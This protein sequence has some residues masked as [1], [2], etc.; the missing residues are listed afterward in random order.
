MTVEAEQ[1]VEQAVPFF[2]ITDMAAALR[3][4]VDGLGFTMTKQ[5]TPGGK[6]LWCWL[7]LGG[8]ALMLQEYAPSRRPSNP[9]GEGVSVCFQCKD[10]LALYREFRSRGVEAK[11][12]FAG[13]AMWVVSVSDPDGHKLDFE[14]PTD[15]PEEAVYEEPE[16]VPQVDPEENR[17]TLGS[18]GS[19]EDRS[20]HNCLSLV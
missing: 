6:L 19:N 16:P 13:N 15:A 3:F 9:L 11:R 1:N 10:A 18:R 8:A 14:S 20:L 5:W 12:P 4:Y 7:Q 2:M 17:M